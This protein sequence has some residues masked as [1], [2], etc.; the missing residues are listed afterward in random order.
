M[1]SHNF[2]ICHDIGRADEVVDQ[3]LSAGIGRK[4]ISILT[5]KATGA[6][7]LTPSQESRGDYGRSMGTSAGGAVGLL[8]STVI[9]SATAGVG[10][11][12]AGPVLSGLL[13]LSAGASTGSLIGILVGAGIREDEARFY[14]QEIADKNAIL[15]GARSSDSDRDTLRQI[16]RRRTLGISAHA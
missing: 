7:H 4:H 15:I 1:K 6:R 8:R 10:V 9:A 14:A 11:L 13:G 5:T 16:M 12:A 3:L 2:C